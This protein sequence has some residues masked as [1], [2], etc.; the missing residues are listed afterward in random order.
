MSEECADG[1]MGAPGSEHRRFESFVGTFRAEVKTW[2]GPGDPMIS[3]GTMKNTLDLGG[4]FLRQDYVGDPN[5][6]PFPEFAGRG[7]RG[8]NTVT[9][10]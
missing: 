9:G 7:F 5:D 3:T 4:R 8:F 1:A 6:G 2:M 10:K